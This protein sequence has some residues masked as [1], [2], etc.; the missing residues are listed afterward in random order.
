MVYISH[1]NRSRLER[2]VLHL[3]GS[4]RPPFCTML[5]KKRKSLPLKLIELVWNKD[6][7]R[8]RGSDTLSVQPDRVTFRLSRYDHPVSVLGVFILDN[9]EVLLWCHH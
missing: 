9:S 1:L 6:S 2:S 5:Q 7:V 3:I 4:T 8:N